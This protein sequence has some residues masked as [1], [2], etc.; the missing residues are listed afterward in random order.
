MAAS[1]IALIGVLVVWSSACVTTM[2]RGPRRPDNE[3]VLVET[4]GFEIA[5]IDDVAPPGGS[6]FRLL[7]G[8]HRL[9]MYMSDGYMR[10][11][12]R[13]S[14]LT[15]S[16]CFVAKPGHAYLARPVYAGPFVRPQIIDENVTYPVASDDCSPPKRREVAKAPAAPAPADGDDAA[17]TASD[18]AA[19][20]R[21]VAAPGEPTEA[22]PS[23]RRPV[24]TVDAEAPRAPVRAGAT[25]PP[26][27]RSTLDIA[28]ELGFFQGGEELVTATTGNGMSETLGA[29]DGLLLGLGA[30]VTPLWL[31]DRVGFGVGGGAGFKVW[32]VGGN[33]ANSMIFKWVLT[34]SG[35]VAFSVQ[36][37]WLI[38]LQGGVEKDFGIDWSINGTSTGVPLQ[39]RTGF[40]GDVGLQHALS[41][42][43]SFVASFRFTILDYAVE[44]VTVGANS[45]GATV[46]LHYSL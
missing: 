39:S 30:R 34:T 12:M 26:P 20:S 41:D 24:P 23:P 8:A 10:G 31:A 4:A 43:M 36:P 9:E 25:L 22:A 42:N 11:V 18:E 5:S 19:P 16:V 32:Q 46:S 21:T 1:R 7:P 17:E 40:V 6:K 37:T 13:T 38:V 29:G 28:A 27:F 3:T 14:R 15:L 33:G 2:Y 45:F 35:H 44:D